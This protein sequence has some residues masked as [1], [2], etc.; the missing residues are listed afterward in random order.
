MPCFIMILIQP[1][2]CYYQQARELNETSSQISSTMS[3]SYHF[4]LPIG[5]S[6]ITIE[7]VVEFMST[8]SHEA[9]LNK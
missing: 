3:D 2:C 4:E 8:H 1:P 5:P 9:P 6:G 7:I